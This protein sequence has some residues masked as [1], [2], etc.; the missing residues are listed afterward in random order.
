MMTRTKNVF[1]FLFL[2]LWRRHF[3]N[4]QEKKKKKAT[5]L[6]GKTC[7]KNDASTIHFSFQSIAARLD[8]YSS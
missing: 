4:K 5:A 7:F 8:V 3:S 1:D 2:F 6:E